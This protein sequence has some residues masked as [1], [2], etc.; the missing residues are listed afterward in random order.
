[1]KITII[2][3]GNFEN[4]VHKEVFDNYRKRMRWNIDLKEIL[5][6]TNKN[7][8]AQKTKEDEAKLIIKA[9]DKSTYIIA[10]D[11]KGKQFSSQNFAKLFENFALNGNS[12]ITFIIGGANGIA[13]EVLRMANAKISLSLM[14]FP[15]LM[16]RSILMEQ[17][18]RA[19]SI[20]AGHPYHRE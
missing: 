18:Y 5:S 19:Q 10:L 13:D 8:S 20:I 12:N 15:H 16:V 17:L 4:N 3:I 6:K 2:S 11:E 7:L 1:M 14:T 9:I